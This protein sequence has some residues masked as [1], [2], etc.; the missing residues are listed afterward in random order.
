MNNYKNWFLAMRPWSFSM[1]AISVSVGVVLASADGPLS[2]TL[3]ILTLLALVALH[4]ATNLSNDYFDFS[5]GVDS[6]EAPTTKYRPHPLVEGKLAPRQIL[7]GAVF[8][9]VL[10]ISLGLYLAAVSSWILLIIGVVG[11]IASIG[12]TARPIQYKYR[13]LGEL[14]VFLVWGP[15]AVGGAYFIQRQSFS[16]TALLVSIPFGALVALVLLANNIRDLDEDGRN[17]IR[18]L[19]MVLG[20]A[21]GRRLYVVLIALAFMTVAL[22]SIIGPL[23]LWSLAVLLAVPMAVSLIKKILQTFPDDAD[24]QT[25][26]LD[27]AFGVLLIVSLI[28]ERI[29]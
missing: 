8:F 27:T 14:S 28:M 7:M 22:M 5:S 18:T 21:N 24:A 16:L 10:A 13:A 12:Y 26:K 1:S 11:V 6:L 4:A 25:A 2:W 19:P 29:V 9:Y 20:R 3:Y 15:L 23:S 17:N